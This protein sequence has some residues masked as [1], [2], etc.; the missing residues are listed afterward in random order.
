MGTVIRLSGV[1]L[2]YGSNCALDVERLEIGAGERVF[3]LGHSGSGKTT[4]SRMVKGRLAPSTGRVEVLGE[5][6]ADLERDRFRAL[7][8]R[9][10][11]IDQEFYLVPRLRVG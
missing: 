2:L 5:S 4:L 10:A 7:Q 3:V 1:H 6:P 11:M 8:R 9:V